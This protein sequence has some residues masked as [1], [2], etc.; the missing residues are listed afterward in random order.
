[1]CSGGLHFEYSFRIATDHLRQTGSGKTAGFLFP[2]LSQAFQNGPSPPTESQ[3]RVANYTGRSSKV[4]PT[5]LILAPTRELVSQIFAE[6]KKFCYRSWVRPAVCYG[7]A[8]MGSQIREIEK[9]CD[10]LAATPGRLVDL[11]DRGKIS[12]E[13]IKYLILDEADR[14]LEF[15]CSLLMKFR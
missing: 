6:A 7:G 12:L 14:M 3:L 15:V 10:L 8:E 5:T 11:I 9:G 4:F 1:M 2:I 13:K